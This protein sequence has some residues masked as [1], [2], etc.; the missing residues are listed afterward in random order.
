MPSQTVAMMINTYVLLDI[1]I[2]MQML[3]T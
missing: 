3:T 1:A 2:L